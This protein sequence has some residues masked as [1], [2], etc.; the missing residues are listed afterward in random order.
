VED[1]GELQEPDWQ[2]DT[3]LAQAAGNL[4]GCFEITIEN[5]THQLES[6][7]AP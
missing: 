7:A 6:F 3:E 2:R 4:D 5:K 1:A